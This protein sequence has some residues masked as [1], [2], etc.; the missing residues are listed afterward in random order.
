MAFVTLELLGLTDQDVGYRALLFRLQQAKKM[1]LT[2]GIHADQGAK[3]YEP[4]VRENKPPRTAANKK[5]KPGEWASAQAKQREHKPSSL[6]MVELAEIHEFGLGVPQRSFIGAWFDN[7]ESEM[8]SEMT[9][10]LDDLMHEKIA[11]ASVGLEQLGNLYVA[12]IQK[13]IADGIDPA[14]SPITIAIK[15]SSVPLIDT[16]QLRSSITYHVDVL[17]QTSDGGGGEQGGDKVP[18]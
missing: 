6:T 15:G 5:M 12:K 4:P 9:Q 17:G 16:G 10:V 8:R 18:V 13:E 1:S 2:V 7:A 14:L 11:S 3:I